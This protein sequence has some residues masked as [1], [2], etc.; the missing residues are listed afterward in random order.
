MK[1]SLQQK[2]ILAFSVVVIVSIGGVVIFANLDSQRQVNRY[3]TRGGQ[4]GVM[5]LVE[6]LEDYYEY[7]GTWS[8]VGEVADAYSQRH[9]RKNAHGKAS[10]LTLTDQNHFIVWSNAG[11]VKGEKL[12]GE[13]TSR[14]LEIHSGGQTVGYL[15]VENGVLQTP[16]DIAPFVNRLRRA[17]F[18]AGGFA[19]LLAIGL[20][21]LVSKYLLEPIK[22]IT[23]ASTQLS[24]GDFSTR[25]DIKG[26]DEIATLAK[27]F[28]QLAR[29][30]EL[31]E[32]RKQSLTADAAHELRTPIAVQKAQLE[33][34]LDGVLPLTQKNV[35]I[36]LQQTNFLSRLVEDLRLLAMADAGE[37][38]LEMRILNIVNLVQQVVAGFQAQAALEG[39]NL[40]TVFRPDGEE[41]WIH[42][43]VDRVS[44]ILQNLI[45]NA[46]RYGQKG[47]RILISTRKES[48]KLVISVQDDGSGIP[49]TALPH[50]FERFYR[51][52]RAR[53]RENGG[54]G[55]G[56]AISKKLAL[57]LGGD[58]SGA[59]SPEGGAVFSLEL[60][61]RNT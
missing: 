40:V 39:T 49:S 16:D 30:L 21:V 35:L 5:E 15:V 6:A 29:N 47:G 32:E 50:L 23:S 59:N 26:N 58:L 53:T 48:A 38:R 27:T 44:Q 11:Q 41:L 43:D 9:G 45:S 14:S 24:T 13:M 55:L 10:E 51:H 8:M 54:S 17:I 61:I 12:T 37:V 1:F 18:L 31:A 3:L 52:E 56:L 22:A 2:M 36:A 60:P 20:A 42:T 33:G 28:N 4:Y 46:L 19:I 57:L 34:M 7:K 25:V